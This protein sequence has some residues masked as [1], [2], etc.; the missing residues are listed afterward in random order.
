[1]TQERG[2]VI[3]F[4]PRQNKKLKDLKYQDPAKKEL[5]KERERERALRDTRQKAIK[6]IGLFILISFVFY[7][8]KFAF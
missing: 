5:I 4:K 3:E 2:K 6:N 1:M 7:L 8:L